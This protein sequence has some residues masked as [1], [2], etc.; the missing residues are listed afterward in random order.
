[1]SLGSMSSEA[2]TPENQS[3][4]NESMT[5]EGGAR[6]I[7]WSGIGFLLLTVI[8]ATRWSQ[9]VDINAQN[10]AAVLALVAAGAVG[11]ERLI[12]IIWTILGSRLGTW[13]PL[14]PIGDR[15][16]IFMDRIDEPLIG[17]YSQAKNLT[18]DMSNVGGD[19]RR[20]L[21]RT[22]SYLKELQDTIKL[23]KQLEPGSSEARAIAARASRAVVGL[24]KLHPTLES[25]ASTANKALAGV[26]EFIQTFE[27][28]PARRLLSIY[29]GALLGLLFATILGL[30]AIDAA[31]GKAPLESAAECGTPRNPDDKCF[32]WGVYWLFPNIGIAATGLVIGLGANPTHELIKLLKETKKRR[33]AEAQDSP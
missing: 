29:V 13:W 17:F 15:L 16:D 12:E 5:S 20:G 32:A 25:Y 7:K 18:D 24:K 27:D 11:I 30:D 14:K 4:K 23:L 2:Q 19:L 26:N 10:A 8:V 22:P 31:L 21:K 1:M 28:N 9:G 6:W 33:K 3:R